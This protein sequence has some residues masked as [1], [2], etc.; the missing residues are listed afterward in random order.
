MATLSPSA[1]HPSR[2]PPPFLFSGP[3]SG[4]ASAASLNISPAS[5]STSTTT[6]SNHNNNPTTT[7]LNQTPSR[8][9]LLTRSRSS[10][11]PDT[12]SSSPLRSSTAAAVAD[13]PPSF[14]YYGTTT[15]MNGNKLNSSNKRTTAA[16]SEGDRATD[17]LWKEMQ[18]TLSDVEVS[19][20]HSTHVF[21][22][23]HAT[24]LEELRAAQIKL[25]QAWGR[26]VGVDAEDVKKEDRKSVV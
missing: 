18:A 1:P 5:T 9:P 2:A 22:Q 15:G 6:T 11:R 14:N 4:N 8:A 26:D 10:R 21:G 16:S 24:A 17:A 3:P 19:A 12:T 7:H 23:A 25:A 20:F 13:V